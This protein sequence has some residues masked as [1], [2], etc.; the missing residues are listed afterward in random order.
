MK[1]V[2]ILY[3]PKLPRAKAIAEELSHALES[4]KAAFWICS[5]WEQDSARRLLA[6]TDLLVAL[7][8][9]GTILRTARVALPEATPILGARLGRVGFLCEVEP[10]EVVEKTG[11]FL[12]GQGWVEDRMMLGAILGTEGE[13]RHALNDVVVG[14]G[15]RPRMIHVRACIDGYPFTTFAA[16]AV[17]LATPTGSTG[18]SMA[19]GGPLVH[20]DVQGI[21]MTP[22]AAH[23]SLSNPL[24]LP[25]TVTVELQV[26]ADHQAILTIDGQTDI[27]VRN[28]DT[29]RVRRSDRVTRFLRFGPSSHYYGV[30]S[31]RLKYKE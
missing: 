29:V 11:A 17:I 28:G 7:G 8:G 10:E 2:G 9:D 5:A 15:Q 26:L 24:V 6:G 12:D 30:L 31:Q 13:E 18:Y 21:V 1:K 22:V 25:A 16:D 19:A 14:R 27:P 4:R 3:H 23:L 20:P